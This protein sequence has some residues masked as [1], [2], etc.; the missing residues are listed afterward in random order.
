MVSYVGLHYT[1]D[2][3][4]LDEPAMLIVQERRYPDED[5]RV[6]LSDTLYAELVNEGRSVRLV[7]RS[8]SF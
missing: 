6:D 1:Y 8:G 4:F 3:Q 2:G 5:G 7:K